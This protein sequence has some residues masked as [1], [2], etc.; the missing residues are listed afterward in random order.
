QLLSKE[1][2]DYEAKASYKILIRSTDNAGQYI[3]KEFTIAI[4]NINEPPVATDVKISRLNNRI[5]TI[6]TGIF[7]YRDP[8]NDPAGKHIYKWYRKLPGGD[9]I[10]IDDVS[11][12]TYTPV[13]SDGGQSICFEITPKDNK[14]LQGEIVRSA[15]VYINAA[16]VAGNV[17][18]YAPD[19]DIRDNV[20]GRY[21]FSDI[22]GN[23][24]GTHTL[25]WFRSEIPTGSGSLIYAATDT[26][27]TITRSDNDMY[28][29]FEITPVAAAGSTPGATVTSDWTGPVGIPSPKAT[30]SGIDTVCP[31]E[32][33]VLNILFEGTAPFTVTYLRIGSDPKTISG[34]EQLNYNLEVVGDGLYTLSSVSDANRRGKVSGTGTVVHYTAPT[35][36]ISGS[37]SICEYTT[38][39]LTVSLTGMPPWNFT[40]R[41][42]SETPATVANVISSPRLIS[43]TEAGAYTMVDVS[44]KYCKGTV[45]GS[46]E[47]TV[48]PAPDV[49][50]T[51]L[52]PAYS[53]KIFQMIP[54]F[55]IP[56][57][58][59]FT[60]SLMVVNDTNYFL[61]YAAGVGVHTIVYSYPDGTTGC[62]GYDTAV[63][64]VLDANA[65]ITFPENDTKKQFC[66]ND[67]PF[68]ILG[69]NTV[70]ATGSFS[71]SGG[72]G[73]IDNHDNTATVY[74]SQLGNGTFEITYRYFDQ[75]YL[76]VTESFAVESVSNIWFIGFDKSSY[77]DNADPVRLNGNVA[78]GVFSGKAVTGDVGSGFYYEPQRS[79]PGF[80]T[81]FY[82]YTTAWGCSRQIYKALIIRDAA[83]VNFTVQNIC[84]SSDKPDSAKFINLTTT[85]DSVILW[86][87]NFGDGDSSNL[88]NPK[89]L[90]SK[91]G[92]KAITLKAQTAY[93]QSENQI[94]FEFGN[95]P[96]A[97]FRLATECFNAGRP[98]R[99]INQSVDSS[100]IDDYKWKF[101]AGGKTDSVMTKNAEYLYSNQGYYEVR[102]FVRSKL[103]CTDTLIKTI[104]LQ[105]THELQAGSS[106]FEGFESDMSGWTGISENTVNSWTLGEPPF[107]FDS[108][109]FG[110]RAW[111]TDIKTDQ[112]G[113]A[114]IEQSSVTSPCFSFQGIQKPMVRLSL[115]SAFNT[116]WNDGAVLQYKADSSIEW[117]NVG[118][119]NDGINWYK[120]HN[121]SGKPGGDKTIGWSTTS[122]GSGWVTARHS[123]DEL[124]GKTD[125]QFRMA[126][127]SDG[128]AIG[129]NGLSFDNFR[130]GERSKIVMIEHFTNAGDSISMTADSDLDMI[131]NNNPLDIIDIQY[132]TS[133]PGADPF[134]E[135][136]KVDPGTR[137]LY[138]QLSSVPVSILNGGTNHDFIFDHTKNHLD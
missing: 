115:Y 56:E 18:I 52:D 88:K 42:D 27:Y 85:T 76:E 54:V 83:D 108:D 17:H 25:R 124:K 61:P 49:S 118:D 90:Y 37:Q 40:Y 93:C 60:P 47:L 14:D 5:G 105:P 128:T 53:I 86:T 69:Y 15:F 39:N 43:V 131:A 28:I 46:A 74:P 125:V 68:N 38:A 10:W 58:G 112:T 34:I 137:V 29:R 102:L 82:T 44:D 63:V 97:D 121:I 106:Y 21:I 94:W 99:F 3:E 2:F 66:Y 87:W 31:G 78:D 109:D 51:G 7:T 6:N 116:N 50:I 36:T 96:K 123:L 45:S 24:A 48:I 19:I 33:A 62:Y 100:D 92:Y 111:Y 26:V 73:L 120:D 35:A 75:T 77:C 130:I 72:K 70:N 136:N 134:N 119:I 13:L 126:Y 101:V 95:K 1:I 65:E 110:E 71:I 114:F 67:P 55:G 132:H 117:K 20:Y 129:T 84:I 12:R 91:E 98:V 16:P 59:T 133:F 135:Q 122:R 4:I 138:Y 127:G 22:E 11:A 9:I 30:I 113:R 80:D 23:K 41:R 57:N 81:V 64:A 32:T 89:H 107:G 104:Q 79:A 103:G 8:D